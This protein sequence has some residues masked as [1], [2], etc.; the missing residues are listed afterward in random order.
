MNTITDRKRP[1]HLDV[2]RDTVNRRLILVRQ[3]LD[4]SA[5]CC[6][7]QVERNLRHLDEGDRFPSEGQTYVGL[8]ND[9]LQAAAA[10][11]F[12]GGQYAFGYRTPEGW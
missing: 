2:D 7:D 12:R 1:V 10:W 6:A 8:P 5:Q 3:S 4:C 11:V 9:W